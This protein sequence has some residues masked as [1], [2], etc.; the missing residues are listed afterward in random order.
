MIRWPRFVPMAAL[1]VASAATAQYPPHYHLGAA[2]ALP[3]SLTETLAGGRFHVT[4]LRKANN[5]DERRLIEL[6]ERLVPDAELMLS[7]ARAASERER[8]ATVSDGVSPRAFRVPP[9]RPGVPAD[10]WWRDEFDGTWM[11]YAVTGAAAEYYLLRMRDLAAGRGQ[12]AVRL[13]DQPDDGTFEYQ[14]HVHR[15]FDAGV[16]YV[17]ELRLSWTYW[18]SDMCGLSFSQFRTVAFDGNG[19]VV[20]ITGDGR[21]EISVS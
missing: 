19:K 20:R 7:S 16:A 17:V 5:A 8:L 15:S 10:R 11:P 13:G 1:V 2:V 21:S 14:A 9:R 4:I 18:C 3:D 12:I 6:A